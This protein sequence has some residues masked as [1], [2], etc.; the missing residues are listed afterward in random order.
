MY[1]LAVV[2]F[3]HKLFAVGDDGATSETAALAS[4]LIS[5]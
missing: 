4:V 1:I 2:E 3:H 5:P